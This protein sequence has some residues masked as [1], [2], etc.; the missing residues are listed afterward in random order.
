MKKDTNTAIT[1][2]SSTT[3]LSDYTVQSQSSRGQVYKF[4][5]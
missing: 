5:Q 3:S 1:T 2:N 4:E